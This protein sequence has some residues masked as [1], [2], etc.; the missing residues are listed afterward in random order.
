MKKRR[1]GGYTFHS[2]I[3][4]YTWDREEGGGAKR[5]SKR[6]IEKA[7]REKKG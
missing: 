6:C 2:R 1:W 5:R 4:R 7:E 3:F